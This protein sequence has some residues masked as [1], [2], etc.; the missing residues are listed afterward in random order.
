MKISKSQLRQII[1]EEADSLSSDMQDLGYDRLGWRDS[2]N[3]ESGMT[4]HEMVSF[5]RRWLGGM[6]SDDLGK[7]IDSDE[8]EETLR[9]AYD[10]LEKAEQFLK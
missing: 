9:H 7:F 1:K 8:D 4:L 6:M 3:P 5:C 2:R 10:A